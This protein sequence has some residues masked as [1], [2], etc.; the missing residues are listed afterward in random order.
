[1]IKI[2]AIAHVNVSMLMSR[3]IEMK[4]NKK[5]EE[6]RRRKTHFALQ[7]PGGNQ[8]DGLP[9]APSIDPVVVERPRRSANICGLRGGFWCEALFL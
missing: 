2:H 9:P 8:V 6:R 1:M 3:Q 7:L 5:I 4:N